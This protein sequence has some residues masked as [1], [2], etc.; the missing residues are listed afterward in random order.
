MCTYI[1][2]STTTPKPQYQH[3]ANNDDPDVHEQQNLETDEPADRIE[4]LDTG[5]TNTKPWYFIGGKRCPAEVRISRK[6]KKRIA[7]LL[8]AEDQWSDRITNQL[9][10]VPRNYAQLKA[11]AEFK[12][13]LLFNG[14]GPWNVKQG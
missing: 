10:F 11:N 1:Q 5:T 6:T 14:L 9:M 4:Q 12:T 3:R 2:I 8:P 7:K 13:I